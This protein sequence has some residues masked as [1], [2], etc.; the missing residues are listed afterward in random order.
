M[1]AEEAA[2]DDAA[3]WYITF[4]PKNQ[5]YQLRNAATGQYMTYSGGIKTGKRDVFRMVKR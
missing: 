2:A 1:T 4:T 5:Y 3:A